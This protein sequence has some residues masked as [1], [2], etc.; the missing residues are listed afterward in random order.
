MEIEVQDRTLA[1]G[2]LTVEEL[3]DESNPDRGMK[4]VGLFNRFDLTP[5]DFGNCG[6]HRIVYAM[7]DGESRLMNA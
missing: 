1:E 4:P 7:G 6:E 3:L 5:K 2:R